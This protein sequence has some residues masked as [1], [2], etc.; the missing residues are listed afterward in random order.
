MMCCGCGLRGLEMIG[1]VEDW[2]RLV[3][4]LEQVRETLEPIQDAI[5]LYDGWWTSVFEVFQNLA[6]TR[7]N[8]DDPAV[9]QFWINILMDTTD[10]KWVGGGGSMPGKPV[11]VDAYD[12]WLVSFLTGR[13]KIL[14]E[15]LFTS[16]NVKK[17]LSGWNKVPLKVS[18]TWCMPPIEDDST[19]VAGILGYKIHTG[20]Q[21]TS[22][23]DQAKEKEGEMVPSIEPNH[24]WAM[25]LPPES[26]LRG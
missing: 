2:D 20:D 18:L 11:Q 3:T 8:P 25:L 17:K 15:E 22:C 7:K 10:T 19:L 1:S 13:K 14:V 16:G 5:L 6:N 21:D 9:V 4:K 26:K 24:M 23:H 12:G